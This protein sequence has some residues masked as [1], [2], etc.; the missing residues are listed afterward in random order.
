M[1][2]QEGCRD[3]QRRLEVLELTL[4]RTHQVTACAGAR[5]TAA[6]EMPSDLRMLWSSASGSSSAFCARIRPQPAPTDRGIFA[7]VHLCPGR[8]RLG[9]RDGVH[10][11]RIAEQVHVQA[12]ARLR[13]EDGSCGQMVV[14]RLRQTAS[15]AHQRAQSIAVVGGCAT[16]SDVV[17]WG[18]GQVQSRAAGL[19]R[20]GEPSMS[21]RAGMSFGWGIS[22]AGSAQNCK[23]RARTH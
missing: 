15:A 3:L 23:T 6:A 10:A 16:G 12:A 8:G 18:C 20:T 9:R 19:V 11:S 4:L 7:H 2:G 17:V 1:S 13:L 21:T 5:R 14:L 22:A